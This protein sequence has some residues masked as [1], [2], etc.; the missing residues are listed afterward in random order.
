[1]NAGETDVKA[2]DEQ[3]RTPH[4]HQ[5]ELLTFWHAN[6]RDGAVPPRASFDPTAFPRLLPRLALIAREQSDGGPVFRYR[7][8]GSEIA[9][10]AGRD[11]T[12]K[13]F[14]E[15]Y[16]GEYL[17]AGIAIYNK[18]IEQG[19]PHLSRNSFQVPNNAGLLCYDRLILPLTSTG[20]SIDRFILH[21]TVLSQSSKTKLVGSFTTFGATPKDN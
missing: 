12:G 9:A 10:R 20:A 15:L 5:Q 13:S 3:H 8:A 11:P 18:V 7:L 6:S 4:P 16:E 2:L 17:S 14:Q 21:I 1:M 19:Q